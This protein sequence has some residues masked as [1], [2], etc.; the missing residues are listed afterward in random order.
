[1]NSPSFVRITLCVEIT[2]SGEIPPRICG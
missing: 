1:M 2:A